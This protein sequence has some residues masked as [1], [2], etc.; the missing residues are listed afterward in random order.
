MKVDASIKSPV[1]LIPFNNSEQSDCW[2]C[3]LGNLEVH[4]LETSDDQDF[5]FYEFFNVDLKS[6][7]LMYL[8]NMSVC[9]SDEASTLNASPLVDNINLSMLLKQ[10]RL[11]VD[12]KTYF[13]DIVTLNLDAFTLKFTHKQYGHLIQ[14]I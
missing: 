14:L 2:A 9:Y 5:Q 3:N 12:P 13:K 7:S 1:L 6:I 8:P 10:R 11:F 4:S